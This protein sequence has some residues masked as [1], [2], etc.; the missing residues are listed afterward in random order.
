MS[1]PMDHIAYLS[2]EIGP[3]PAGTEEEQ[4]AALYITERLQKDAHLS[5]QIEDF[6][7]NSNALMTPIICY[8][9]AIVAVLLGIIL[10]VI[11]IPATVL[12][13]AAAG[14][15]ICEALDHPLLS[16]AFTKGVSQN[17]VAKYEP[18]QSSDAAGSRRRKVIVVANYDS[19]KVRRETAGVFVRAL[20]PLR[21]GALG[22]MVVA[23]VFTLLRGVVLSEGAASLVLAVLAGV[24]LIPSAVLLVFALLEKFGPFTE[25]ANDNASGV[26]V[27]LEVA[28]RLGNGEVSADAPIAAGEDVSFVSE[29]REPSSISDNLVQLKDGP[30]VADTAQQRKETM[31][32]LTGAPEGPLAEV[33]AKAAELNEKHAQEEAAADA[34]AAYEERVRAR[35]EA[36]AAAAEAARI[37]EKQAASAAA[38]AAAGS[39]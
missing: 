30:I 24:C 22:G 29:K 31:A 20:R 10:P 35:H 28:R 21:Y 17:I 4:Q 15:A 32:A 12:A 36:E 26:A 23:A 27:M 37:A 1:T 25:A 6:T 16:Q 38:A 2:Q 34:R 7:C 19:G 13:L 39:D 5:A 14:I 11:A 8:G 3:R 9:V 18:T 33:A